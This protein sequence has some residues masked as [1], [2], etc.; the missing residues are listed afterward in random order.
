MKHPTF[1]ELVGSY[2]PMLALIVILASFI[3]AAPSRT[4]GA[5]DDGIDVEDLLA[6][7]T[8][9]VGQT[10]AV[11]PGAASRSPTATGSTTGQASTSRSTAASGSVPNGSSGSSPIVGG[12][13]TTGTTG[14]GVAPDQPPPGQPGVVEDCGRQELMTDL[15]TCRPLPA[16]SGDNGGATGKNVDPDEIRVTMYTPQRNEQVEAMLGGTS[17]FGAQKGAIAAYET[18]FNSVFETYGRKVKFIWQ[19]GPG[20][21]GDVAAQAADARM[22]A[23]DHKSA[24]VISISATKAFHDEMARLQ[25]PAFSFTLQWPEKYYLDNAPYVWSINPGLD[26]T[27][28]HLSEYICDRVAHRP[29]IH[30]GDPTMHTRDR[31]IGIVRS[32][33]D[34]F[35]DKAGSRLKPKLKACGVDAIEATWVSEDVASSPQSFQSVAVQLKDAEVTTVTCVC[36]ALAPTFLTSAATQQAYFPEY[37]ISSVLGTDW[38]FFARLYDQNQW[39]HAFGISGSDFYRPF[40]T[41][42]H[43]KT[44]WAGDP[45]GTPEAAAVS[46]MYYPMFLYLFA[47][48]EGAGPNLNAETFAQ[49]LFALPPVT[50]GEPNAQIMSFGNNGPSPFSAVDD[51]M[52]I[53]WDPSRTGPDGKP[54]Y[55]HF[56][57]SGKRYLT[58]SW[59]ELEPVV[60]TDDGSAQPERDPDSP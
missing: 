34:R 59:P 53:W 12:N 32:E 4:A 54:G 38:P 60:F 27:L 17:D 28:D 1:R 47:G 5:G 52:E 39:S 22:I 56:V 31:L 9:A 33:N 6:G 26:L 45:D 14:E 49:A 29:A 23:E 50:T 8:G 11:S 43:W 30:A 2:I 25:I 42:P 48:I 15:P 36:N 7:P 16:F 10:E 55:N 3:A 40:A 24:F 46:V 20:A 13:G 19:V 41:R 18:Y 35:F 44:Y 51:M 37:V 21:P 58:G 57:E